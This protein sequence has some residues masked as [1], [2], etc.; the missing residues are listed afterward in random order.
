MH[1]HP[2]T[3]PP[4]A[5]PASSP[6]TNPARTNNPRDRTREGHSRAGSDAGL[7]SERG[8]GQATGDAGPTTT[9]SPNQAKETKAKLNQIIQNYFTKAAQIV[10]QSRMAVPPVYARGTDIK[11]VNKWFNVELD[12]TDAFREELRLWKLCDADD[13]RPPSLIIETFLDTAALTN[14][15][16]LVIIDEQGKRWNVAE[17]LNASDGPDGR[18]NS[19]RKTEVIL[20]RWRIEL[21]DP[22]TDFPSDLASILPTVYKKSI[23]LF[24]SLYTYSKFL[25][26]WK[27]EKRLAKLKLNRSALSVNC[28]VINGD[29]FP[30]SSKCDGLNT[31]LYDG[32][33]KV[34]EE[35]SFGTIDSP[36]GPFTV[37]VS[38]RTSCEFRVDDSEALLSSHFINLDEHYFRPSLGARDDQQ[39]GYF[40]NEKEVGSLPATRRDL[41]DRPDR[42]QAY[43]SLSTFHHVAPP[44]SSSPL[45]ALRAARELGSDSPSSSPPRKALPSARTAQATKVPMKPGEGILPQRRPSVSFQPFKAPSLSASPATPDQAPSSP[46]NSVGR[47]PPPSIATQARN[48]T[49]IGPQ[50]P[51]HIRGSPAPPENAIASSASGSPK[52]APISRYGS[53]FAH[54]RAKLSS[55]GTSKTDDDNN[56]SGK[57]S[58]ASSAAQPGSGML[59]EG[60]QGGSSGSVQTDDDNISDFLKLLDK[61]KTLKSFEAPSDATSADASARRPVAA[62]HKFQKMR[63]SNAALSDSMSSSL[64]LHRSST[65]SSRQ[66]SSVPTMVAGTSTSTSSSPGKP[67]SPHTPHTPAIPSRLSANSI[68]EYS[69]QPSRFQNPLYRTESNA[70]R[71]VTS[72]EA[73]PQLG[74]T[75]PLDIPTSPRP[76]PPHNRRSSSASQESRQIAVEDDANDIFPFGMRSAS[77]GDD[78]STLDDDRPPLSL[79]ALLGLR[80]ASEQAMPAPEG[81][82]RTLQPAANLEDAGL[83]MA[84]QRS[85]S[86]LESREDGTQLPRGSTTG[87]ASS[88]YRPR[89]AGR[90]SGRGYTPPH[91]SYSSLPGDR[92]GGSGTSERP[93]G[94]RYSFSRPTSHIEEDEP[95]LFAMSEIG[96]QS[97]RSLEEGRQGG[98]GG[99]GGG[100][101]GLG[102]GDSAPARPR[103]GS[104]PGRT[105]GGRGVW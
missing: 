82:E 79:S 41:E 57:G 83:P 59:M 95:L 102:G 52:A 92:F 77:M 64:L 17:A 27:F 105:D 94:G 33:G 39:S 22:L 16:T 49:S 55:G 63:D 97:R 43:G 86:S 70:E 61:Q 32:A 45:S 58:L 28:R 46:R 73:A 20:E 4:T 30:V 50:S 38:Y 2:R 26:A 104:R 74:N 37:K 69:S 47:F 10:I 12:E 81:R 42:G 87:S 35:F 56:S 101:A 36:A 99:G 25:P 71:G 80:E 103:R 78:R 1:Q 6:W 48:R 62:L 76:F 11:K 5:S 9:Q 53:S 23:V 7:Y 40:M 60:G 21:G 15:E 8:A 24:R 51:T 84:R 18:G 75:A 66:L 88:P 72:D 67:I 68:A 96:H 91:T 93:S 19:K 34:V 54:R 3:P 65:S 89:L 100:S 29:N 13:P 44:T 98:A 14:K 90:T 31:P 85:T